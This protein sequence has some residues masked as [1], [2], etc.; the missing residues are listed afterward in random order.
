MGNGYAPS[1]KPLLDAPRREHEIDPRTNRAVIARTRPAAIVGTPRA[2]ASGL[3]PS[4]RAATCRQG[5]WRAREPGGSGQQDHS[6]RRH[7][8]QA[9]EQPGPL[10]DIRPDE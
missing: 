10:R 2:P 4:G 1:V 7:A 5:W 8:P 6:E 3:E 9:R